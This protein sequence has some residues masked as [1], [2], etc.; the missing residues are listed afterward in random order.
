VGIEAGFTVTAVLNPAPRPS[1]YL[2]YLPALLLL[3]VV[4][5]AQRARRAATVA[6]AGDEAAER[7][8]RRGR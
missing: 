1:P 2:F 6:K 7:P 8:Q 3:G 4:V 5:L